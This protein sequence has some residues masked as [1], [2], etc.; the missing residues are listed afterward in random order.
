ML[1]NHGLFNVVTFV[2]GG[3]GHAPRCKPPSKNYPINSLI[4]RCSQLAFDGLSNQNL[5]VFGSRQQTI[6]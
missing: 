5:Y 2:Y 4:C 3:D 1:E 6:N